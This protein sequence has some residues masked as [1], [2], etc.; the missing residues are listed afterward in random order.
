[1]KEN[2]KG[3]FISFEGCEGSGKSTV[4]KAICEKLEQD[5]YNYL[6]TREPGGT[7]IAEA[8]RSIILNPDTPEMRPQTE[9]LLYAAARTQHTLE[10][11]EP[12]LEVGKLVLCDR[13]IDSSMAYQGVARL[14]GVREIEEIN[15]FGIGGIRPDYVF[16]FDIAPEES[17]K[18]IAARGKLDRLEQEKLEFHNRVYAYFKSHEEWDK[19][20]VTIDATKPLE[21]VIEETY[22][23]IIKIL[24]AR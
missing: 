10:K 15:D 8:I 19:K 13:Y 14:L 5:G 18:R 17:L 11:I 12:A 2:K 7:P 23:N 3:I 16:F 24:E 9:A 22:N 1:M 20:Y 21:H 4:A 6:F